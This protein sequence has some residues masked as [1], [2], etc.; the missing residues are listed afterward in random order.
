MTYS[1]LLHQVSF[2]EI[3]P[4][5]EKYADEGYS[6][7]WYKVHY[8]MLRQLKPHQD[9]DDDK[10]ATISNAKLD[11]DWEKPRLHAHPMEGGLWETSLAKELI[12]NDDVDAT[13]AEI[14]ACCLWHTSS[15]GT[16]G[17]REMRALRIWILS[18]RI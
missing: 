11:Y 9:E 1:E 18:V 17:S 4:Y 8:D 3:R 6:V 12:V 15:M 14:A 13:W 16:Q 7:A 10:T 5:L 2:D